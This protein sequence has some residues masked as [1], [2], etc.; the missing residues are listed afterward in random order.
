[1]SSKT[2]VSLSIPCPACG[3]LNIPERQT[4]KRCHTLL[5][6]TEQQREQMAA[7]AQQNR[8][9]WLRLIPVFILWAILGITFS[10]RMHT[11]EPWMPTPGGVIDIRANGVTILR[12]ATKTPPEELEIFDDGLVI[13]FTRPIQSG[14][15]TRLTLTPDEQAEFK[16]FRTQWCQQMPIFRPLG[17]AEPFYDLGVRCAGYNVNQAKV[18]V[19]AL[20]S[21][22][23]KLLRRLPLSTSR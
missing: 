18:P 13:H 5:T 21:I 8:H 1:M 20:P 23:T 7:I 3:L 9:A 12:M 15:D 10:I 11:N 14:Q 16:Q 4:C 17:V 2:T 22:F 19:D 6:P